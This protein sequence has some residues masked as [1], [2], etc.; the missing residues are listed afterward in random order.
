MKMELPGYKWNIY[1][2]FSISE[3]Y[4]RSVQV[5]LMNLQCISKDLKKLVAGSYQQYKLHNNRKLYISRDLGKRIFHVGVQ[6]FF[7]WNYQVRKKVFFFSVGIYYVHHYYIITFIYC[8]F[9]KCLVDFSVV[10]RKWYWQKL[11]NCM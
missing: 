1:T 10:V 8:L 7:I 11:I 2:N 6:R 9:V 3:V 5:Q 4:R